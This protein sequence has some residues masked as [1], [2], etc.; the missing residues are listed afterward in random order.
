[1]HYKVVIFDFDGTLIDSNK[2]KMDVY[3]K[4]FNSISSSENV[5]DD[6]LKK[7][8]ELNRYDTI[9][10]I[11]E[12]LGSIRISRDDM[13]RKYSELVFADII[14]ASG[15]EY[16]LYILEKLKNLGVEIYLSSNTPIDILNNIIDLKGWKSYFNDI[17]GYPSMK[18]KTLEVIKDKYKYSN[19]KYLVVGDGQSDEV[20]AR[21]NK[22]DFFKVETKSLR[23]LAL[24][25]N[26]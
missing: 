25:L 13:V 9:D 23:N 10:K 2:I 26:I 12:S 4:I 1:M 22:V 5:I 15:I 8:P 17:F 11:I 21:L 7:Y 6:I 14:T 18:V 20:S 3:Y 16:S 19:D 24:Q